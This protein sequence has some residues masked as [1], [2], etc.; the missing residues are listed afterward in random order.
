MP[1][2]K[3]VAAAALWLAV[4]AA[5]ALEPLAIIS[6][7]QRHNFQVEVVRSDQAVARGLMFRRSI[8]DDY[9]MLFDFKADRMV[10]MWMHNTYVALDML[11]IDRDGVITK[12]HANARPLDDSLIDSGG[13]VRA[14]LEIK[15]GGA[16]R[17]TI[18]VGDR[19][20]HP[21]FSVDSHN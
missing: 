9:G 17:R 11:F 5:T 15:A 13:L 6:G 8:A 10:T 21:M 3:V 12:I 18:Q 7:D 19:V 20:E 1:L 14:V 16:A 4:A 2:L